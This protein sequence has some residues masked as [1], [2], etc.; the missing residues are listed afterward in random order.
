M[1]VADFRVA[2]SRDEMLSYYAGFG[3]RVVVRSDQGA[4]IQLPASRFRAF[5]N[6][7]GVHGRFRLYYDSEGRFQAL[8]RMDD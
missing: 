2:I 4:L 6:H 5:V 3:T 8:H 1:P 7:D